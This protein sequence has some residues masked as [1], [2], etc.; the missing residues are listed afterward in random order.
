VDYLTVLHQTVNATLNSGRI[1]TPVFVRWTASMADSKD[2]LKVQLVDMVIYTGQWLS[3][4]VRRLYATGA[5]AQ[6]HLC[7]TLE[8]TTGGSALA[9]LALT[10]AHN[11]PHT[12]LAIYGN[13]GAVYHNEFIAPIRDGFLS[14][15]SSREHGLNSDPLFFLEPIEQSL[16]Q[17]QPIELPVEGEQP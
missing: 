7:L 6:G 14:P 9:L 16:A 15:G 3:A 13:Q 5:E 2:V 8:Y 11:R 10:L 4:T 12:S 17:R 1:G